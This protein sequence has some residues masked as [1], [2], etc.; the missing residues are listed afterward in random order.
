MEIYCV[1][2]SYCLVKKDIVLQMEM[3]ASNSFGLYK[4]YNDCEFYFILKD[5]SYGPNMEV[6]YI[7]G[8]G[9]HCM[10]PGPVKFLPSK[11]KK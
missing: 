5:L 6:Y 3:V 9:D 10:W 4:E 7:V 1:M 8:V 11:S 2:L